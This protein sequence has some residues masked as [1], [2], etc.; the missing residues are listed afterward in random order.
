[1]LKDYLAAAVPSNSKNTKNNKET[2]NFVLKIEI[3]FGPFC[4][5]RI[6]RTI[7]CRGGEGVSCI[8]RSGI[9]WKEEL[10]ERISVRVFLSKAELDEQ[11]DTEG[12]FFLFHMDKLNCAW[13]RGS[14]HIRS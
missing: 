6:E 4:G 8:S 13:L 5:M 7:E 3:I 9:S 1:M 2:N 10:A 11:N 14:L 12:V